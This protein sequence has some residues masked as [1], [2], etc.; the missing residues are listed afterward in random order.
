VS[1]KSPRPSL[2]FRD[3]SGGG[4]YAEVERQKAADRAASEEGA[5]EQDPPSAHERAKHLIGEGSGCEA[6]LTK[7]SSSGAFS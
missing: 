3:R 1:K 4:F 2:L 5:A 6:N 7:A